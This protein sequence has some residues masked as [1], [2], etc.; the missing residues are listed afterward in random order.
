MHLKLSLFPQIKKLLKEN[1]LDDIVDRNLKH[2]DPKEVEIV[3]QVALLC[4]QS[5]PEHRPVMTEVVEMLQG[6]GLQTRWAKW[7]ETEE[8]KTKQFL[9]HHFPWTEETTH[10]EAIQLSKAR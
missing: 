10:L 7:E 4:T 2:Y 8:E 6:V 5:S 1:R 9:A 3:I